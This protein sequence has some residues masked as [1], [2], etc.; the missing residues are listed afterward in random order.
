MKIYLVGGAVR[1]SFL[2]IEAK[3]KD[4]AI[5]AKSYEEMRAEFIRLGGTIYLERPEFFSIRG[6]LPTTG[7]AD[8]TLCRKD[9][10]YSDNRRPDSVEVGTIYDDLSRRDMTVNAIAVNIKTNEFIDPFNGRRDIENRI[11]RAVGDPRKRFDE[12][13]LRILRFLRFYVTKG[14]HISEDVTSL[15]RREETAKKLH[16]VSVERIREELHKMF[17][18]DTMVAL[19]VLMDYDW[20]RHVIFD[21]INFNDNKIWLE[22]TLKER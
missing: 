1:D 10:F 6:N 22:P 9:G 19:E 4:Y 21:E 16:N 20:V 18:C 8:F 15:I 2:G 17:S 3:D 12:D 14:F 5:E 7:P 13:A 11:L